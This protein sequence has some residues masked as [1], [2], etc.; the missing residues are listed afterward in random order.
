MTVDPTRCVSAPIAA[1]TAIPTT[2]APTSGT[3][4]HRC[5]LARR[6]LEAARGSSAANGAAPAGNQV[7]VLGGTCSSASAFSVDRSAAPT[8]LLDDLDGCLVDRTAMRHYLEVPDLGPCGCSGPRAP[9]AESGPCEGRH[10][11]IGRSCCSTRTVP[12]ARS[13]RRRHGGDHHR[14]LGSD[15]VLPRCA[16][17]LAMVS[18]TRRQTCRM[19]TS[20][21]SPI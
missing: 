20:G 6:A 7:A 15:D 11:L 14:A 18:P 16:R 21:C 4:G 3:L 10:A 12:Q 13:A 17:Q 9:Q 1:A 5:R 8:D 19:I 2:D